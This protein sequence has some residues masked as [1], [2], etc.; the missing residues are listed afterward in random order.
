M[1]KKMMKMMGAVLCALMMV[2]SV[3]CEFI[4]MDGGSSGGSSSGPAWS[5]FKKNMANLDFPEYPN[6]A[7]MTDSEWSRFRK[8]MADDPSS[9]GGYCYRKDGAFFYSE[10][11]AGYDLLIKQDP[12][13]SWWGAM[14][15]AG[16]MLALHLTNEF[17]EKG[18][19]S[20][21][22]G[23]PSLKFWAEHYD[24][25]SGWWGMFIGTAGQDIESAMNSYYTRLKN[26]G[27]DYSPSDEFDF[28]AKPRFGD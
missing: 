19:A 6:Y 15:V 14:P 4:P 13:G 8:D 3:S 2:L 28:F 12:D 23:K 18:Y 10:E 1:K 20:F 9:A 21:L 24:K 7:K 16:N 11:T 5:T 27:W 22:P 26:D 17:P 25:T